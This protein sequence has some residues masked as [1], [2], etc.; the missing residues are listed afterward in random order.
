MWYHIHSFKKLWKQTCLVRN[1]TAS[2]SQAQSPAWS[3]VELWVTFFRHTVRGQGRSAVG[4]VS[5]RSIHKM[6]DK[7]RLMPVVDCHF[8]CKG[9]Q[10]LKRP[11]ALLHVHPL[12]TIPCKYIFLQFCVAKETTRVL[13]IVFVVFQFPQ[14][15]A[16]TKQWLRLNNDWPRFWSWTSLVDLCGDTSV[17]VLRVWW[18]VC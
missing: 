16:V 7:S 9:S 3:R 10:T 8:P 4:L 2:R 1:L 5:R 13:T 15:V 14:S 12:S 17:V 6:V 18:K 11:C